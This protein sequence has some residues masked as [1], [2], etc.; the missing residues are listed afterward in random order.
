M[1]EDRAAALT[2]HGVPTVV[3]TPSQMIE[4][5]VLVVDNGMCDDRAIPTAE[6]NPKG[7][8]LQV[9]FASIR[10]SGRGLPFNGQSPF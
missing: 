7:I 3:H 10:R 5:C 9:G 2:P 6:W 4:V 1:H 8:W